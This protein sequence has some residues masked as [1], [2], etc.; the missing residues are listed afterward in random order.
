MI[1]H[2]SVFFFLLVLCLPVAA[3]AQP[4]AIDGPAPPVPPE[5]IAR[6][7]AGKATVRAI[8]LSQALH[9]DGK[10]DEE[11]YQQY[12]SFGGFLQVVPV[13]GAVQSERREV[14]VMYDESF[15][16]VACRC[17]DSAPPDKWV[18]NELRRDTNQLRQN[19]HLGVMFD[20]FYDR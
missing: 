3:N 17:W 1:Q 18:A 10:L 16:Y 11:V 13:Y 5:M 7:A 14:W 8:K 6:D 9:V 4:S 15:I 12:Q 2:R 20:T 19:D